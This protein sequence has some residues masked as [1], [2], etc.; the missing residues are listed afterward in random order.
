MSK[1]LIANVADGAGISQAKTKEV[2]ALFLE[3]IKDTLAVKESVT[4][5]NFGRFFTSERKARIGRNPTTGEALKIAASTQ[6]RFKPAKDFKN[7][8]N[9]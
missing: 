4:F 5:F 9:S 2:I 7:F 3:E 1:E 8:V 6:V